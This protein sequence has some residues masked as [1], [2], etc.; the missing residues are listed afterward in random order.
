LK[1]SSIT[2]LGSIKH[3]F[4]KGVSEVSP[5]TLRVV[6]SNFLNFISN[7]LLVEVEFALSCLQSFLFVVLEFVDIQ[8]VSPVGIFLFECLA[9][10]SFGVWKVFMNHLKKELK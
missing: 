3:S 8:K 9:N 5:L 6:Y 4:T 10:L 7:V 2:R 1:E